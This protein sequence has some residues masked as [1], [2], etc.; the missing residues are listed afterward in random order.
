MRTFRAFRIHQEKAQIVARLETIRL[1]ALKAGEVLIRVRYS[2]INYKD[3]LAATGAGRILRKFWKRIATDL[4][5]RHLDRIV[6]RT[7]T[8]DELPA[9]FD[10]YLQ[11]AVVGRAVVKIGQ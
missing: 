2:T 11:A 8:L 5:P 9:A 4:K 3:A 1:D 7:V 10:A 6:T